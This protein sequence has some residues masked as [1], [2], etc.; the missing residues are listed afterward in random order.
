M[1]CG[2]T[3]VLSGTVIGFGRRCN[4]IC[5]LPAALTFGGNPGFPGTVGMADERV[6]PV[7]ACTASVARLAA[8]AACW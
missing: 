5:E 4:W 7:G 6:R 3:A 8:W 2:P 1:P